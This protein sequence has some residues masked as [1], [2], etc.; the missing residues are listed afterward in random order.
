MS[1]MSWLLCDVRSTWLN[2][3]MA[4]PDIGAIGPFGHRNK[5]I[6]HRTTA[7]GQLTVL[8]AQPT[9]LNQGGE[10]RSPPC[11]ASDLGATIGLEGGKSG[12]HSNTFENC[13]YFGVSFG[14]LSRYL[15]LEPCLGVFDRSESP[16]RGKESDKNQ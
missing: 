1:N 7:I 16:G 11:P 12:A 9:L 6:K 3:Q 10:C 13:W 8:M 4:K 5:Y 2:N 15:G 14:L